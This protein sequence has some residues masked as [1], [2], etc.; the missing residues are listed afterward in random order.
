[1]LHEKVFFANTLKH[2]LST[3]LMFQPWVRQVLSCHF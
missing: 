3:F 2:Y 1:L